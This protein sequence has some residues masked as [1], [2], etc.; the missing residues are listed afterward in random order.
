M[1]VSVPVHSQ[2][3]LIDLFDYT[4]QV[5]TLKLTLCIAPAAMGLALASD[6]IPA[7]FVMNHRAWLPSPG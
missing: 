5:V 6:Q 3:A 2:S 1:Y 4:V 7:A